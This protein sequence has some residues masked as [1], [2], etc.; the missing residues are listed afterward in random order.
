MNPED[1]KRQLGLEQESI[2]LGISEYR[3][4]LLKSPLESL[5]TGIILL[6]KAIE[7][8]MEA[9][10]IYRLPC[11]TAVKHKKVKSLMSELALDNAEMAYLTLKCCFQSL[12]EKT[13]I[14]KAIMLTA[15]MI[16]DHH[17]YLKFKAE[18]P[19]YLF[20]LMEDLSTSGKHHK[21]VAMRVT[22]RKLGMLDTEVSQKDRFDLGEVLIN[23]M[24]EHTGIFEKEHF[25][26]PRASD[27]RWYLVGTPATH[28]WIDNQ[29]GVCEVMSPF[30]LPMIIPPKKW[31]RPTDG[32]Y[33]C[34]A[35]TLRNKVVKTRS[36]STIQALQEANL[37]KVYSA[38]NS[39]QETPWRINKEVFKV[40]K[41]VWESGGLLGG[42]PS[43]ELEELP[44]KQWTND[45]EWELFKINQPKAYEAWRWASNDVHT[46]NA[47]SVGKRVNIATRISMAEKFLDESAIYY[48]H[49]LDFRG[50]L[51]PIP[52]AG[53][54]QPQGDDTGKALLQFAEGKVLTDRGLFW[55]CIHGANTFGFDKASF[56]EREQ[57][58]RTNQEAILDSAQN[59]MDGSRFWTQADSPYC[60]LA[61]CFEYA[62]ALEADQFIT[63][64]PVAMDGSCNGL[65]QFS[66]LL[67]DHVGGREVNLVPCE[68]PAD[69]YSKVAQVVS[70]V[71]VKE[72]LEGHEMAALWVGKV[73]RKMA[74]RNVM[75]LPYGAKK[76]GFK[77]QLLAELK[78]R[79][80]DYLDTD[81]HFQPAIYLADRMFTGIGQ[82]V[83][84][85]RDA[86]DW[87][88]KVAS[89]VNKTGKLI[90]WH[91][92]MGFVAQQDYRVSQLTRID[93]FWGGLRVQLGL[94]EDTERIDGRKQVAALSPNFIHSM[95]SSHLMATVN[96]LSAL[97]HTSFAMIHDSYGCLAS[98]VEVMNVE[99]REA[100]I[101]MYTPDVLE[102]F[103]QEILS[104][105]P[106]ELHEEI[107]PVPPK[108]TLALNEVRNSRYFF[109]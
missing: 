79:P 56:E 102:N 1:L 105:L 18:N 61:F 95:D 11:N 45:E 69:I 108:G 77:D 19:G 72:A 64:L 100:F 6:K 85:A 75:T 70:E 29:N 20:K 36:Q 21:K 65:Q 16:L 2:Q 73:D 44:P 46:R 53:G 66:A 13:M 47:H 76:F 50:R 49:N 80:K 37:S 78:D 25:T 60:F 109:A 62:A 41:E 86:M 84:A 22:K 96:R 40:F 59:P 4:S 42:L 24:V 34:D 106:P 52:V 90:E 67:R 8:L 14:T 9:I 35:V 103:R 38:I 92:P 74:K 43:A 27:E 91:T 81:K 97:G 39:I 31:S 58:V 30:F 82:V 17:E 15:D 23:L 51:Y 83:I 55:L 68:K 63:H 93:T 12:S 71:I 32:G 3:K 101:E 107:P 88:Q 89:A 26:T 48:P 7:P 10:R 99:L 98:D 57:W 28:E 94:K 5:P 104:Q 87:L 54:M 33:Y